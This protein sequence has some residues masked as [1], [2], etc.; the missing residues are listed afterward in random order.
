MANKFLFDEK[1]NP[2][3]HRFNDSS[4]RLTEDEKKN[5]Y[6]LDSN[7]SKDLW[8]TKV[9]ST[10]HLSL[11]TKTNKLFNSRKIGTLEWDNY[12]DGV[13]FFNF[14]LQGERLVTFFWG[15]DISC[16]TDANIF[17]KSWD[18]FFYPSD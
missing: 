18:D 7:F 17:R 10:L 9:S 14:H 6:F 15:P 3:A 2:I 13:D 12:Q 1:K 11:I 16:I 8:F 4:C 5:I